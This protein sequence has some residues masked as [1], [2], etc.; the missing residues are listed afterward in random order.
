MNRNPVNQEYQRLDAI[1]VEAQT[2]K[3]N[4]TAAMATA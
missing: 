3:D 4:A 1:R 2:A